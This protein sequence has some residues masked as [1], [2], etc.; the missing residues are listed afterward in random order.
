M[1]F[2][3][4]VNDIIKYFA[5]NNNIKYAKQE[6]NF[7]HKGIQ[8]SYSA[9]ARHEVFFQRDTRQNRA[10]VISGKQFVKQ[11]Q[12]LFLTNATRTAIHRNNAKLRSFIITFCGSFLE[13]STFLRIVICGSVCDDTQY[14]ASEFV[15]YTTLLG[16]VLMRHGTE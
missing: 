10:L 5:Q 9:F 11:Y 7:L 4:T 3:I 14:F 13:L 1:R 6:S 12:V 15:V 16:T 2:V 8:Y